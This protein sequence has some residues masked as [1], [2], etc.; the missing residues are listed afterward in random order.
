MNEEILKEIIKDDNNLKA[1][2][3][4]CSIEKEIR[5]DSLWEKFWNIEG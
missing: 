2:K 3:A 5:P 4:I 1:A